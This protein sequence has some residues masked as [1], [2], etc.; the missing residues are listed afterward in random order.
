MKRVIISLLSIALTTVITVGDLCAAPKS[1]KMESLVYVDGVRYYIHTVV[2]GDTLYSLSKRYDVTP[3]EIID[4]NPIISSGFNE[5][6]SIKIPY[7]ESVVEV[8]DRKLKKGYDTH[9]V[10]AGETLYA[11]SRQYEISVASILENNPDLDPAALTIGQQINIRKSDKGRADE[12]DT[13]TELNNYREQ[14]NKVVDPGL[15]YH[16]VAEGETI[17][18]LTD[19]FDMKRGDIARLNNLEK[20][21]DIS[22]GSL[23]LVRDLNSGAGVASHSQDARRVNFTPLI[24]GD[25]LEVALLLPLSIRGYAMQPFVEFYQG[26]LLGVEALKREGHNVVVNLFNTEKDMAV[27]DGVINTPAY[28]RSDLIVGPVYE[29]LLPDVLADAERRVIPVVSPLVN[30]ENNDS[31]VLFQ[32]SPEPTKRFDKMG[33]LLRPDVR[34]TLIYGESTDSLYERQILDQLEMHGK[35]YERY[36]Y[37]YEHPTI[38]EARE[39]RAEELMKMSLEGSRRYGMVM[40]SFVLDSLVVEPSPSDLTPLIRNELK[41]E[42]D[43]RREI[44]VE[45][46]N[47]LLKMREEA[48][49]N[50]AD[51]LLVD[52]DS[53]TFGAIVE[54]PVEDESEEE[55]EVAE[56]DEMEVTEEIE[57]LEEEEEEEE[58]TIV[59]YKENLFI[60]LSANETE[61]DRILSALSSAYTSQVARYRGS[62]RVNAAELYKYSLIASPEW[63]KYTNIDRTLYFSN[64]AYDFPSYLAGRD[65]DVIR[66]FDGRYAEEFGGFAT[67]YSYRGYDVARI[68]G[69]GMFGDIKDGMEGVGY[70]PLQSEYRFERLVGSDRVI[71]TNWMRVGYNHNFSLTI[72]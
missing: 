67:L 33:T 29:E 59:E 51:S 25:T 1:G 68:F 24:E 42:G 22:V 62:R 10:V 63:R 13:R 35:E 16:L 58:E 36:D 61:V 11:I 14:L 6:I 48:R 43:L 38:I 9:T 31:P 12:A 4:A 54:A 55:S 71:N 32:M 60:V 19:R 2:K 28:Q 8:S 23:I 52:I 49:A 45:Y 15:S 50:G 46:R 21:E 56:G 17:S 53:V 72:E 65:S 44:E 47:E 41:R 39:K 26:F 30:I 27:I 20:G 5:G 57:T 37:K 18:S 66:D 40:D 7:K 34:V 64:K 3:A 70:R 69:E